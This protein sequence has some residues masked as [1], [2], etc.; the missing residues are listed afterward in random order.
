[1]QACPFLS[2][3]NTEVMILGLQATVNPDSA[4]ISAIL[5]HGHEDDAAPT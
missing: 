5:P 3:R 2:L 1:M 4:G